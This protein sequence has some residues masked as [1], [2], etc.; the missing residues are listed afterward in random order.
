MLTKKTSK[1]TQSNRVIKK[2][3]AKKYSK[4]AFVNAA[5]TSKERL[6]LASV[7]EDDKTYTKDEVTKV[8][9]DWKNKEVK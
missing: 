2:P 8:I 4:T 3:V 1:V 6:E 7:L 5:K 9:R